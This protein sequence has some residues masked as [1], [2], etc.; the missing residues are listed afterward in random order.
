M[1]GRGLGDDG[2]G[3]FGTPGT[4][5]SPAATMADIVIEEGCCF[6]LKPG[7]AVDGKSDYGR[8]GESVVVRA[9]GAERLGTAPQQ[10]F[11][12]I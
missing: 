1:H 12:L 11:E 2:P 9:H 7:T 5:G 10:L 3:W 6:I 8:W 4:T